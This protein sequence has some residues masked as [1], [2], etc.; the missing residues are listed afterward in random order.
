M[1]SLYNRMY[2]TS[3]GLTSVRNF[4]CWTNTCC[5]YTG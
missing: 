4:H 3:A 5:R 2:R 1:K